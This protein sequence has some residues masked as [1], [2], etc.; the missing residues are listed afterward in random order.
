MNRPDDPTLLAALLAADA[1]ALQVS[2]LAG[3]LELANDDRMT[4]PAVQAVEAMGH[5]VGVLRQ[6]IITMG[7][8]R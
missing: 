4:G 8:E 2:A 1:L 5:T 3:L 6:R 7:D